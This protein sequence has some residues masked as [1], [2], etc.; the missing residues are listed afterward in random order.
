MEQRFRPNLPNLRSAAGVL[1]GLLV[2]ISVAAAIP[3]AG[4]LK[5]F[6]L[7]PAAVTSEFTLW[8][9]LTY[10]FV[11]TDPVGVIFGAMVF[12]SVGGALESMW[13]SRRL[14]RFTLGVT[15]FAAVMTVALAQVWSR[16]ELAI[17]P[18][19]SVVTGALIIAFGMAYGSRLTGFFGLPVTGYQFALIGVAFVAL[20]AAFYGIAVVVPSVFAMLAA[21]VVVRGYGPADLLTR[22]RSWQLE[23]DLKKRAS[24]LSVVSGQKRN[25]PGDSDKYLH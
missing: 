25:M 3:G 1:T 6:A 15:V 19:S 23:R 17:Y 13:G 21:Y 22:F 2:L 16:L 24:H 12:L 18:G 7:S 5:Y 8:T 10:G 20:S 4:F 14:L 9:L 11:A